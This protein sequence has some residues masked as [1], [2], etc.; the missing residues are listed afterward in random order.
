MFAMGLQFAPIPGLQYDEIL[1]FQPFL[2]DW[3]LYRQRWF[4]QE[5]PLMVMSY[6]G[7]LKTWIFWPLYTWVAPSLWVVRLPALLLGCLNVWLLYRL[8]ARIWDYR[9]GLLA[10]ALAASDTTFLL[11]H[12]FDWGPVGI[13]VA[14]SAGAALA[15]LQWRETSATRWLALC[16]YLCGLALWNKAIFVWVL[17]A[18]AISVILCF[19][20]TILVWKAVPEL[21]RH[22]KAYAAAIALFI[23]GCMPLL[24]YNV[25]QRGETVSGNATFERSVPPGKIAAAQTSLDGS[26]IASYM[27]AFD[28]HGDACKVSP[29]DGS[30]PGPAFPP[31]LAR[32]PRASLTLLAF[33]ASALVFFLAWPVQGARIGRLIVL[34]LLLSYFAAIMSVGAGYGLHHYAPILPAAFLAIGGAWSVLARLSEK[35]GGSFARP[36][37]FVL[38]AVAVGLPLASALTLE[39]WRQRAVLCGSGQIWTDATAKLADQ[40]LKRRELT[41]YA[42]DWGMDPQVNYLAS[43]NNRMEFLTAVSEDV[44]PEGPRFEEVQRIFHDPRTRLV[45]YYGDMLV[46][47]DYRPRF[48]KL[49]EVH[50]YQAVEDYTVSD[51][52][53]RPI[54]AVLKLEPAVTNGGN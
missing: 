41:F 24:T 19:P 4:G 37:K 23:V 54:F 32:Y 48:K 18:L 43:K 3:A 1:F 17:A 26:V 5:F 34:V 10:A 49:L 7:A 11:T 31:E 15:F 30:A 27:F 35:Y 9:A 42:L 36:A 44:S 16:G 29:N 13:Q 25:G 12:L 8:G 51:S 14:L 20:R 22:R 46:I 2:Y 28:P 45:S 6:V 50:G 52:H 21:R 38:I 40:V 33:G 53:N 39:G 47:A